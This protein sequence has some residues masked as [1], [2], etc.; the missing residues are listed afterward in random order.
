MGEV[1]SYTKDGIDALVEGASP[2]V[3]VVSKTDDYTL[4]LEDMGKLVEMSKV[5]EIVLT[6][7]TNDA[8]AYPIGTVIGVWA[9]DEGQVVVEGD[10]GVT[11]ESPE[12]RL[13]K[14][15]GK[16]S[17]ASL[18]KRALNTWTLEGDLESTSGGGGGGGGVIDEQIP[19]SIFSSSS[20]LGFDNI[21]PNRTLQ[22][23]GSAN[24]EVVFRVA[25]DQPGQYVADL[26]HVAGNNRGIYSMYIDDELLE[27]TIDGYHPSTQYRKSKIAEIDIA[28]AGVF[29]VKIKMLSR[30][31]A[32]LSFIGD[33]ITLTFRLSDETQEE[34]E[35]PM[36]PLVV[37]PGYIVDNFTRPD[38]TAYLLGTSSGHKWEADWT[39]LGIKD[40]AAYQ[41]EDSNYN[42][43]TQDCA[44]ETG[45]IECTVD[46]ASGEYWVVMHF[47]DDNN[48]WR[49]G[50]QAGGNYV[51]QKVQAGG[52]GTITFLENNVGIGAV[53]GDVLKV[54]LLGDGALRTLVNDA[55]AQWTAPDAFLASNV[56]HGFG[57]YGGLPHGGRIG[58][59]KFSP[60]TPL[61]QSTV[62]ADTFTRAD[63]ALTLGSPETG[64]ADWVNSIGTF[65]VEAGNAAA[66]ANDNNL[67]LIE[68]ALSDHEIIAK[69]GNAEDYFGVVVRASDG[70][71]YYRIQ[72][73][74]GGAY[75]IL[76][77]VAGV[78]T[79]A[80]SYL[81]FVAVT[82]MDG[83][84]LLIRSTPDDG[85]NVWHR[86][87]GV[88]DW[89]YIL[90]LGDVFNIDKTKVGLFCYRPAAI[91]R[92]TF[93]SLI[94]KDLAGVT[95]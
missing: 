25:F 72:S 30:N 71:N 34:A 44:V 60:G 10:V 83:D 17:G 38:N 8:V 76:K 87:D 51:L 15:F 77:L 47:Q 4:E 24:N 63:N 79:A 19:V 58:S 3:S 31:P 66:K 22:S 32:S 67:A 82:P 33:I 16:G 78:P 12:G 1:T 65:G 28:T 62:M 55:L 73:N 64:A 7:P 56:H 23:M 84:E 93:D 26:V 35:T 75:E 41:H 89:S 18:R 2:T 54:E 43:V 70:N 42:V 49:F 74:S 85:V 95:A 37:L 21:G 52:L 57:F 80:T 5:T 59:W 6:V 39:V 9:G 45:L 48:H 94:L 88:E 53:D 27:Y 68:T 50:R 20:H 29:P 90:G 86:R 14:L 46:V 69:I 61:S 92:G 13:L 81:Q 91:P 11:V 40:N 36:P